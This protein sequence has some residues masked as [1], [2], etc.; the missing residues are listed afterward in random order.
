MIRTAKNG[1]IKIIVRLIGNIYREYGHTLCFDDADSDLNDIE[2]DYILKGGQFWV[3]EIDNVIIGTVA[4]VPTDD[5]GTELKR[6]YLRKDHRGSGIA[7]ELMQTAIKWSIDNGFKKLSFWSDTKFNRG[8][9]FYGKYGFI[10]GQIRHMD[11]G[12]MPYSEYFFEK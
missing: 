12:S 3:Y 4:V 1:D 11:N 10:Q 9:R 5:V 2:S 7:D 8:H 6:L